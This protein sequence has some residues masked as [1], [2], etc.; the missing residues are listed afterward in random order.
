[1]V[2]CPSCNLQSSG[3]FCTTC[4]RQI[5]A[6][7]GPPAATPVPESQPTPTSPIGS[8][9]SVVAGVGAFCP[10]LDIMGRQITYVAN[11]HGDGMV[12]L[13]LAFIGLLASRMRG[14]TVTAAAGVAILV[15]LYNLYSREMAAI[16]RIQSAAAGAT[17]MFSGF[18]HQIAN[19]VSVDWGLY[20][21]AGGAA[22]M[23]VSPFVPRRRRTIITPA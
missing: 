17:G 12:V 15:L 19:S 21:M 20:V 16:A 5:V 3:A 2:V 9:G 22:L 11:G 18:T 8:V 6:E 4:G 13:G 7:E 10:L 1:M 23:I 14:R